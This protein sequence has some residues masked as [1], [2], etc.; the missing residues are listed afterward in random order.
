M[1]VKIRLQRHGKKDQAFFHLVVAD[2]RAPRD[3]KFIEKLGTYNPN[4][5]P[6]TIDI[7]FD[8]TLSWL[9]KGAQPTDTCRAILSYKGVMMKK[10]LLEGVKKGALTEAQVEEKFNKWV[11]EKEGKI[12]GKKDNLKSADSK[13]AADKAKAET[14]AKEAKAA[15]IA[16]KNAAVTETP[17]TD[18]PE[19]DAPVTD[20]PS[21][22]EP[23]A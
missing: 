12:V 22:D 15:K 20:A 6:A 21:T 18:A 23:T 7:N 4:S 10:H 2:G 1:A 17:V 11:G 13:K 5:N 8:S 14:V 9:M 3:G 16:A 19:T